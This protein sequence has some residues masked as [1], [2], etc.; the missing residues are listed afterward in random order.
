MRG[1]SDPLTTHLQFLLVY[2]S[3][4]LAQNRSFVYS[5]FVVCGSAELTVAKEDGR[6]S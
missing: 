6:L 5:F 1:E 2:L 4:A 3:L